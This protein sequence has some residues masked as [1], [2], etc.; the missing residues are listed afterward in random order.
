[1]RI[2]TRFRERHSFNFGGNPLFVNRCVATSNQGRHITEPLYYSN[3][4]VLITSTRVVT[5]L[6]VCSCSICCCCEERV[7]GGG[8]NA[9]RGTCTD[10]AEA[11]EGGLCVRAPEPGVEPRSQ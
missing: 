10:W 5:C 8:T 4:S 3:N 9:G 6:S 11:D 2:K 7:A 1:M